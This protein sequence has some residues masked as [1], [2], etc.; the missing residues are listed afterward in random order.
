MKHLRRLWL[1]LSFVFV[2]LAVAGGVYLA[3]LLGIQ[4]DETTL[5]LRRTPTAAVALQE[6]QLPP[7]NPAI[8]EYLEPGIVPS[9][10]QVPPLGAYL[11][12]TG[13][14]VFDLTEP[15]LAPTPLPYPTS[16]PLPTPGDDADAAGTV[17]PTP[18]SFTEDGTPRTLPYNVED[19]INCAPTGNP[20]D[21]VLTQRY[22][23][24]HK[25]VD[26]GVPLGTPVLATQS[27]QVIFADWSEIG[28]GYL[29][30]VQSGPFITYY[31]HN[32]SFNVSVGQ[33]I[34]RDSIIAWSGSTGNSSGPHVHY[35]TR[36][37]DIPVDP[38]TFDN[39]GFSAC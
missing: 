37:N 35:E 23:L 25:G 21:G 34:G 19:G 28:Y 8:A 17:I 12:R 16:P 10:P 11:P 5:T 29:V 26:V 22:H 13:N 31:A 1:L 9:D 3:G 39:R 7:V 36:I 24:Y 38:L 18:S 27:G 30:I 4:R 32:T 6:L 20:V 15:T 33:Y 14:T 2:L